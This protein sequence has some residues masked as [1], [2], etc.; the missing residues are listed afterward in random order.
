MGIVSRSNECYAKFG[1]KDEID[2]MIATGLRALALAHFDRR[3]DTFVGFMRHRPA[4]PDEF[5]S[6]FFHQRNNEA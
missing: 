4:G 1:A 3:A 6:L 5:W 2:G